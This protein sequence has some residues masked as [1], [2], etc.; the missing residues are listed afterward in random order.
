MDISLFQQKFHKYKDMVYRIAYTYLKNTTDAEDISQE[1]FLKFYKLENEFTDENIEK[2]WLIRVTI[3][4]CHNIKK[5]I[6]NS[7]RVEMTDTQTKITFYEQ[8]E[9]ELYEAVFSLPDK[10]RMVVLLYYYE[11][12]SIQEISDLTGRKIS[13]IQTQLDRARKKLKLKLSEKGRNSY[14][15]RKIQ[16]GYE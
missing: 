5:S 7:R 14:E 1:T 11:E 16:T 12:Y 8:E 15:Q 3:N 6:W 9:S 4:A 2:A 10:Y 13:T